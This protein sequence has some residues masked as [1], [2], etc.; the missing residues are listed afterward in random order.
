MISL[1]RRK[2]TAVGFRLLLQECA[3][4]DSRRSAY[5][6][7]TV[8]RSV[9][10]TFTAAVLEL[11]LPSP[12]L[13]CGRIC[14][15]SRS[16]IGLCVRCRGRLRQSPAPSCS[17]CGTPLPAAALPDR[18]RCGR[19]RSNPPPY[20]A[21]HTVW[22]YEAP[23][24]AVLRRLKFS[25]LA[26]LA[27]GLGAAVA[28]ELA[29]RSVHADA[30][31][32]V[33]L[34][35]WRRTTRGFDQTEEISRHLACE[36]EL[37][38]IRALRRVRPTP[39]QSGQPLD[40]RYTNLRSAFKLHRAVLPRT[41]LLVDDVVTTGATLT[42]AAQ[43]L[44]KSSVRRVIAVAVARTPGPKETIHGSRTSPHGAGTRVSDLISDSCR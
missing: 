30:V 9:G 34:H 39:P 31:V 27:R 1:R 8:K 7:G 32:P 25:R 40:S 5:C 43:A 4:T 35:W 20:T 28:S 26:Y 19:C 24:D 36:L 13:A 16:P 38:Q 21:L 6:Y 33:P 3:I 14:G 17:T 29:S 23:I 10:F 42:A 44:R 15:S 2:Y 18:Y 12:C 11:L 37:P 22:S 41:V